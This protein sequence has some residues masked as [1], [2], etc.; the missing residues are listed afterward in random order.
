LRTT[1]EK[2]SPRSIHVTPVTGRPAIGGSAV[3]SSIESFFLSAEPAAETKKTAAT[4]V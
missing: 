3:K 2:R 1:Y 4:A